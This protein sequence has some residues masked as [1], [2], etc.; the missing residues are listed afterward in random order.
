VRPPETVLS[1]P[2]AGPAPQLKE[3]GMTIFVAV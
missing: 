2:H 1:V 3:L